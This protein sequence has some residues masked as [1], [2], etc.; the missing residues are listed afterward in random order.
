MCRR[1]SPPICHRPKT[2]PLGTNVTFSLGRHR[3]PAAVLPMVFQWKRH[4]GNATTNTPGGQQSSILAAREPT[5]CTINN[6]VGG[7]NAAEILT[8]TAETIPP[9][10]QITAPT[11]GLQVSNSFYTVTGKAGDNVAVSNVLYQ[12]NNTGWNPAT[13]A[14]QWTNW[15]AQVTLIQGSNTIKAYAVD[16]SGNVSTT[17]TVIFDY[18]VSGVL[19]VNTNG[20]GTVSPNYNGAW[21]QIGQ[22]YSMTASPAA[23][24]ALSTGRAAS[25]P[26]G[27]PCS[28]R[29]RRT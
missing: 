7:T 26:T 21:L 20:N 14:N 24:L 23:G 29:W 28:S 2:A 3:Q 9:T 18:I 19:T 6:V 10:N 16:T 1:S 27:R 12:L 8:V 22:N 11:S 17:N 25:R 4:P 13:P 15:T 5:R